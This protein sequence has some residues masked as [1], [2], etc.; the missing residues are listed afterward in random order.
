MGGDSGGMVRCGME[1][2]C[3]G[4][5]VTRAG[6]S[7][8]SKQVAFLTRQGGHRT[9]LTHYAIDP[10]YIVAGIVGWV[11]WCRWGGAGV[12]EDARPVV[13]AEY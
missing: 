1:G 3:A 4:R 6:W 10:R 8:V 7:A 9:S 11:W 13:V 12:G 2:G 5:G